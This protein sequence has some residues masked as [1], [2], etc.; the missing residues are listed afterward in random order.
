METYE[1]KWKQASQDAN[2]TEKL[3]NTKKPYE[4]LRKTYDLL[5]LCIGTEH[6]NK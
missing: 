4:G 1:I 2:T 3:R 5:F 6:V